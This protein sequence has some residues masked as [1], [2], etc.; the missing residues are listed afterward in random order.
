MPQHAACH[1]LWGENLIARTQVPAS[2]AAVAG[3]DGAVAAHKFI[4]IEAWAVPLSGGQPESEFLKHA[5]V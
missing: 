3:L 4:I 1:V 5:I 2:M